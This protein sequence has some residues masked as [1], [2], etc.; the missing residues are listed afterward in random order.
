[1]TRQHLH[2]DLSNISHLSLSYNFF[3]LRSSNFQLYFHYSS[4]F[5]HLIRLF[6][7]FSLILPQFS[8][9]QLNLLTLIYNA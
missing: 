2:F 4:A 1:M 6:K 9:N 3:E 5:S 7:I 8:H